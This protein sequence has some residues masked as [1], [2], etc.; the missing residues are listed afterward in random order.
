MF[1][2]STGTLLFTTSTLRS[3]WAHFAIGQ[4]NVPLADSNIP[5]N[6]RKFELPNRKNY[7]P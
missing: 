2:S 7:H 5:V 3:K 4:G 6:G 1:L